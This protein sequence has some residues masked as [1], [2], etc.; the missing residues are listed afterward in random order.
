MTKDA[1][2]ESSSGSGSSCCASANKN[3]EAK[4]GYIQRARGYDYPKDQE[5]RLPKGSGEKATHLK[6]QGDFP[7][8]QEVI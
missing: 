4:C 1:G 8:N 6:V 3:K 5:A 7:K 2:S